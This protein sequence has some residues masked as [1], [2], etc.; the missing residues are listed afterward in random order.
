MPL[1]NVCVVNGRGFFE[2]VPATA[3]EGLQAA[4]DSFGANGGTVDIYPGS[5][6]YIFDDA[7]TIDNAPNVVLRN[8]GATWSFTG[9]TNLYGLRIRTK[10]TTLDGWRFLDLPGSSLG[11]FSRKIVSVEE[12]STSGQSNGL[13]VRDCRF[14]VRLSDPDVLGYQCISVVGND[15]PLTVA[16]RDMLISGCQFVINANSIPRNA[17][18]GS[19]AYGITC[20]QTTDS[21]MSRIVNNS[22]R[23]VYQDADLTNA[24][25]LIGTGG[26]Y[27]GG[28]TVQANAGASIG[29]TSLVWKSSDATLTGTVP[30]TST[31]VRTG[32]DGTVYTVVQSGTASGNL[33]TVEFYPALTES[34]SA[35]DGITLTQIGFYGHLASFAQLTNSD[36]SLVNNNTAFGLYCQAAADGEGTA[37]MHF[38]AASDMEGHHSQ[39]SN[40]QL[41]QVN[42]KYVVHAEDGQWIA[43]RGNMFGRIAGKCQAVVFMDGGNDCDVTGN[44]FH[45]VSGGAHGSVTT[46]GNAIYY[47]GVS[48]GLIDGNSFSLINKNKRPIQLASCN[49]VKRGG[50]NT[51]TYNKT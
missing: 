17:F 26:G 34:F 49:N 48:G 21:I 43:V 16:R 31:F 19:T 2:L 12:P 25:G 35:S 9:G 51:F 45:N 13:I 39:F 47:S 29:A 38:L 8:H 5:S 23:G 46:S 6:T 11:A 3:N 15:T 7:V 50:N 41:E 44:N 22:V 40:N 27:P 37:F 1:T 10:N 32:G 33:V 30:A 36:M 42:A 18:S 24:T 14:E 20:I 4:I 28:Q